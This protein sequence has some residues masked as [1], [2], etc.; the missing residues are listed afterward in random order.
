MVL[1]EMRIEN[2][3]V[4][5]DFQVYVTIACFIDRSYTQT[6]GQSFCKLYD[7]TLEL[8]NFGCD[9][10]ENDIL[11]MFKAIQV[12]IKL[13]FQISKLLFILYTNTS[14]DVL[15]QLFDLAL[16]TICYMD[17]YHMISKGTKPCYIEMI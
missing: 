13:L 7:V 5:S 6:F 17:K 9:L 14:I 2:G 4:Y 16:R 8:C 3:L 11:Y 1:P 12:L 15:C 10:L